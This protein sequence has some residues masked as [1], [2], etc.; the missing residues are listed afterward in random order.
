M[1]PL[2][3]GDAHRLHCG[4]QVLEDVNRPLHQE[5]GLRLHLVTHHLLKHTDAQ[6]LDL[7][8]EGL[9]IVRHGHLTGRGILR[10]ISR[11]SLE[12]NGRVLRAPRHGARSVKF[13]GQS[14]YPLAAQS[15]PTGAQPGDPVDRSRTPDGAAGIPSHR[16]AEQARGNSC[17]R[18]GRGAGRTLVQ[19]PGVVGAGSSASHRP[20]G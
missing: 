19:V 6:V 3:E 13:P 17:T 15:T 11:D 18:P 4:P 5:P 16:P 1:H 14:E 20:F 2:D 10:V 9:C 7:S 12:H 8:G